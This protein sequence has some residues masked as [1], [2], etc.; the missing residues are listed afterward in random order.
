[1]ICYVI[2]AAVE[3]RPVRF[4]DLEEYLDAATAVLVKT[5]Y[6]GQPVSAGLTE[7][8]ELLWGMGDLPETW[9]HEGITDTVP[10]TEPEPEEELTGTGNSESPDAPASTE[11]RE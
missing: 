2:M 3:N 7:L 9:E 6:E 5:G 11:P 10:K 4:A 8:N 1:M